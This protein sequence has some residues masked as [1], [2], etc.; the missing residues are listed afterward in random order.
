MIRETF[1][2]S[3]ITFSFLN[4]ETFDIPNLTFENLG[5][6]SGPETSGSWEV[7]ETLEEGRR[8]VLGMMI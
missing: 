4:L 2:F 7:G 8:K 3:I 6:L 5:L 1:E